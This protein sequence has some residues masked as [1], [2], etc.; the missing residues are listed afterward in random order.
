MPR[1]GRQSQ[2]W[3]GSEGTH[4]LHEAIKLTADR[5]MKGLQLLNTFAPH[6]YPLQAPPRLR[7]EP[8]A[9]PFHQGAGRDPP[10]GLRPI[11]DL[12]LDYIREQIG[13]LLRPRDRRWIWDIA[14]SGH[15]LYPGARHK[16]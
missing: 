4:N 16:L 9:T 6:F 5:S 11:P 15:K 2:C 8:P 12:H 10:F 7:Q 1:V 13:M 14:C 3:A